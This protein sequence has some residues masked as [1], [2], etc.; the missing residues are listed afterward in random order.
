[1]LRVDSFFD[2][3]QSSI[4]A[5]RYFFKS[6][7]VDPRHE[8]LDGDTPCGAEKLGAPIDAQKLFSCTPKWNL[9]SSS[10]LDPDEF[11][12]VILFQYFQ[13]VYI[14]QWR[15]ILRFLSFCFASPL[16]ELF[17]PISFL[18][19]PFLF[20]L[21]LL[22][23]SYEGN[24]IDRYVFIGSIVLSTLIFIMIFNITVIR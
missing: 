21:L 15:R 9:K 7:G 16:N 4:E 23:L 24:N 10:S 11:Y 17:F 8:A 2:K 22:T 19:I 20:P 13:L 3:E 6:A 14:N 18:F 12:R 1:M 5:S